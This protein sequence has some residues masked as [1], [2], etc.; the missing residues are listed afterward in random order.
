MN[1]FARAAGFE[2]VVFAT[3]PEAGLRAIVAIHSTRLGPSLGGCRLKAYPDE[4]AALTD[5]LRL[6]ES[7]TW[8]AAAAGLD[9]G[10]GKAVVIADPQREKS[11]FLLR[12][13]GRVVESL[14]GRYITSVD[15][16]TSTADLDEMRRETRWV[17][18]ASPYHGGSG[19]PSPMTALGVAAGIR[20]CAYHL[21][22]DAS[23]EGRRVAIQGTG[24]VGYHLAKILV[25]DGAEVVVADTNVDNV[26]RAVSDLGVSTCSPDEI[27]EHACDVLA[28]CALGGVI[29]QDTIPRLKCSIVCGSANNQLATAEDGDRLDRAGILYAPDFIVNAGGL[30]SVADELDGWNRDRVL[31]RVERIGRTLLDVLHLASEHA[32]TPD[33]AAIE[34]ARRRIRRLGSLTR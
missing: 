32:T 13:F 9:L 31:A 6:A 24:K 19:D 8:K 4:A 10:G 7:M 30:I 22:R 33:R 21:W 26:G 20:F 14:G 3:D 23:L 2:R 15:V 11:E 18:G 17:V 1:V 34:Y 12:A 25:E 16:G 5:V 27:L 28:P 29:H